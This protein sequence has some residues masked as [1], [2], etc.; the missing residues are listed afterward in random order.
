M[1]SRQAKMSYFVLIK[2]CKTENILELYLYTETWTVVV[3]MN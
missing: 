1:S 2:T 3:L